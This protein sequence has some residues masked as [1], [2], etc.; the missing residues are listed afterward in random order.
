MLRGSDVHE[1]EELKRQGLGIRAI[2]RL[3]G[4]DR[5]SIRK[6]LLQPEGVPMY[7]PRPTHLTC[8]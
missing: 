8:R 2:R 7:G 3:T 1:I 6:Y 4:Y 5:K